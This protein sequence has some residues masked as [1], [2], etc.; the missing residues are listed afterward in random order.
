MQLQAQILLNINIEIIYKKMIV[1]I[2][3]RDQSIEMTITPFTEQQ[4][5]AWHNSMPAKRIASGLL[6]MSPQGR[7]LCVKP[8]YKPT[9]SLPGG[10]TDEGESP[11]AGA[12]RELHEETKIMISEN[13]V[14]FAGVTYFNA[15]NGYLDNIYFIFKT[16]LNED[17]EI[18]V[19]GHEIDT[20]AWLAPEELRAVTPRRHAHIHL[21]IDIAEGKGVQYREG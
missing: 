13:D 14:D 17:T 1:S 18:S 6:C 11:F 15:G 20:Y 7:I 3:K 9:W 8:T 2:L 10:V 5:I 12:L 16:I 21:A 19:D 4:R